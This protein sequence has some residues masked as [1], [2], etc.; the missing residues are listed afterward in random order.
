MFALCIESSHEK[1]MGHLYRMLNFA[2]F[3]EER[4]HNYK[5]YLNNHS[6]SIEVLNKHYV[7]YEIVDIDDSR[8]GWEVEIIQ[9]DNIEIWINDRLNTESIHS[10][11]VKSKGIKLVTF[12]D[13]GAGA[14]LADLNIVALDTND[15]NYNGRKVLK[16]IRYLILNKDIECYKRVRLNK[17]K[18]LVTLGGSDTYGVTIKVVHILKKYKIAATIL[19]GPSFSHRDELFALVDNNYEVKDSV[20]SLIKEFYNYD[21]AITGGGI[22]P[23]EANATGLPCILIAN[24]LFE[25]PV[26]KQ[27]S[28][29]GGAIFAGHHENIDE[30]VFIRDIDIESMSKTGIDNIYT[31]GSKL[32]VQEIENIAVN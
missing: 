6:P 32:V 7:P 16:G 10:N 30:T 18:I 13:R 26:A 2:V 5:F 9:R 22:T 25:I 14:E 19:M 27:L 20:E 3:L 17:N 1:G 31:D 8:S 24:E 4:K 28:S 12:D 21:L 15:T 11:R 23:F 29:I